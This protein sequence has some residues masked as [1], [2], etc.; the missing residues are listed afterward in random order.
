[1][2]MRK[3]PAKRLLGKQTK[4]ATEKTKKKILTAALKVFAKE[5]FSDAKLRDIAAKTGASHNLIRHHFG[6]KD[7]LWK[8]VVD[9]GLKMREAHLKRIIDSGQTQDPIDLYK[10][11]IKSH[12]M[13][14]AK[15]AELAKILMHSNSKSSPHLDYIIEK[16]QGVLNLIEPIFR[17]VQERGYFKDFDHNS[18]IIYMRAIAETPI[19]TSDF[20]NKLLKHDIRSERGIDLHA[21]RV[22]DFLFRKNE[23]DH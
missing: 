20:T 16:Q 3:M 17:K 6:S 5:G 15:N 13:F 22:I 1:M 21:K 8:A 10:E 18:F 11:L 19:A 2:P 12:V 14:A 4:K 23:E 7:D 9:E